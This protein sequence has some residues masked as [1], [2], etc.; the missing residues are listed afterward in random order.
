MPPQDFADNTARFTGRVAQYLQYR[1]RFP[2]EVVRWLRENIGLTP[3]W[4]VAD[5]GA[6]TGMLSELFLDIGCPVIAIEPNPGMRAAC[7]TLRDRHPAL[8]IR[9]ATAEST[10]L[11]SASIDLVAAGRAFHWFDPILTAAE[12]R[13]I[14]KPT[15]WVALVSS[16][17]AQEASPQ[18][19]DYEA[20]LIQHGVDYTHLRDRRQHEHIAAFFTGGQHLTTEFRSEQ[21]LT[22]DQLIGATQSYSCSPLPG[23]PEYPG[24]QAALADLFARWSEDGILRL[25][26]VC[27]VHAGTLPPE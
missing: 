18:S 3:A 26:V 7:E 17:R 22:L 20:I 10:Q 24:M 8:E 14:L 4:H 9:D 15:G 13:R 1:T 25:P 16:G 12:F 19:H 5:I 23:S 11:P 6:G 27:H 21:H 2:T